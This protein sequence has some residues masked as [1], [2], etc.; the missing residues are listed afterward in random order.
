M[1]KSTFNVK[2]KSDSFYCK[3]YRLH[4]WSESYYQIPLIISVFGML[5][6]F[7]L[8]IALSPL[9]LILF[10]ISLITFIFSN[11]LPKICK[12]SIKSM[13]VEKMR[14]QIKGK[15]E[16]VKKVFKENDVCF[17][18]DYIYKLDNMITRGYITKLPSDNIEYYD[19]FFARVDENLNYDL[20]KEISD[21]YQ[22]RCRAKIEELIREIRR[23][24]DSGIRK[25]VNSLVFIIDK[26]QP[27]EGIT[28]ELISKENEETLRHYEEEDKIAAERARKE[29]EKLIHEQELKRLHQL[30]MVYRTAPKVSTTARSGVYRSHC[31]N[32]H[33]PI[34][35]SWNRKC[36]KCKQYYICPRC[37]FCK[38][39][40]NI[41][42]SLRS[43][44]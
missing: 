29:K 38:C 9:F 11:I 13:I 43:R 3:W 37:G 22:K 19:Y 28:V 5:A 18:E 20:K 21:D 42:N 17:R 34:D 24:N 41:N 14:E 8:A 1:S 40:F 30:E 39:M 6:G 4:S 33:T 25:Y 16:D 2:Y 35:G 12:S 36:P 7:P 27:G 44:F 31:W 26:L 32:C 23:L 10:F 15:I